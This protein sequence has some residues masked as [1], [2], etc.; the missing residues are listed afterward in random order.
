M[1]SI[2]ALLLASCGST[3]EPPETKESARRTGPPAHPRPS[4]PDPT[5]GQ[6][7]MAQALEGLSGQGRL[8]AVIDTT[9]GALSCELFEDQVPNTV[10]NFV[11]LARGTRP[12]WDP[13]QGAWV[14]R[15]F[16]NG[17]IFHR[18]IPE[19]MIQGGCPLGTGTGGPG[20]RFTD[21]FHRELRHSRPGILSMANAGPGT[22]GS[23]FFVMDGRAPHLDGRHS[24]FGECRPAEVVSRIARVHRNASDRPDTDVVIRSITIERRR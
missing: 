23:Q 14:R 7:T 8:T 6:F 17:L 3:Q 24:V 15:P 2:V 5:N 13:Y 16:Y 1:V 11:G 18:V 20:Y 22:N 9:M 19:F 10:A 4:S 21:E 12:W